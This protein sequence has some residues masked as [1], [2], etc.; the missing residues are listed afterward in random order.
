ML[1]D[2]CVFASLQKYLRKLNGK[3]A[4]SGPSENIFLQQEMT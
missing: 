3:I 1:N 4:E 2:I